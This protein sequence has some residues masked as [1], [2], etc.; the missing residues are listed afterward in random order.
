MSMIIDGTNGLTFNNSTVQASAG[1]VL[2]VVSATYGTS[3]SSSTTTLA[4]TGLTATIT[5]KFST[6]KILVI[7][8]QNGLYCPMNSGSSGGVKLTLNRNSTLIA[9][10]SNQSALNNS[11]NPTVVNSSI[12]YLDSPATVS[13]TTYST[14]FALYATAGSC[15]VQVNGE[16][17]AITLMEIAA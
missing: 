6:S 9:T 1:S 11:N 7:V 3:A 10:F 5:P 17:S 14:Q 12:N 2:Q 13:A 16:I 8:S 4:N 15:S